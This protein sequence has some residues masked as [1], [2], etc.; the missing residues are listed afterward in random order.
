MR[1][2]AAMA[3]NRGNAFVVNGLLFFRVITDGDAI[4]VAVASTSNAITSGELQL[5]MMWPI[6]SQQEHLRGAVLRC[7]CCCCC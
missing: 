1:L 5:V 4:A 7:C 2:L 6:W 3:F